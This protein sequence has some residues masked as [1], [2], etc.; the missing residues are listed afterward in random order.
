MVYAFKRGMFFLIFTFLLSAPFTSNGFAD[1]FL[2]SPESKDG[3]TGKEIM[4]KA[5]GIN[6]GSDQR[7]KLTFH[8]KEKDGSERKMVMQRFWKNYHGENGIDSKVV[9]FQEYPPETKGS[10]FMGWFYKTGPKK[11]ESWLY[12]P[13]LRKVIQLPETSNDEAFQGSDLRPGDMATRNVDQD[14]HAYL[15]DETVDGK[16]YYMVESVPREKDPFYKYGKVVKWISKDSFLKERVDYYDETGKIFKKQTISWKKIKDAWVWD[17]V[18]TFNV[19]TGVETNLD[20]SDIKIDTGLQDSQYTERTLKG[21][22]ASF[23]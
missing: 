20:V 11:S 16:N 4:I 3:I 14:T 12:I 1:D 7:S 9:I 5:E 18:T 6:P 21:G 15:G 13:I 2:L 19:Q 22:I 17:K 10:G 23:N 8:F